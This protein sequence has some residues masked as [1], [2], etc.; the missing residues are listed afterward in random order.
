MIIGHKR[1]VQL[2]L[3]EYFKHQVL[4]LGGADVTMKFLRGLIGQKYLTGQEIHKVVMQTAETNP[5]REATEIL[6]EIFDSTY[7]KSDLEQVADK[8]PDELLLD[9]LTTGCNQLI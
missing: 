2:G 7:A 5:T 6:A 3:V 1:M 8:K 4:Q 9:N